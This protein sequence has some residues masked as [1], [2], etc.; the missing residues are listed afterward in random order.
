MAR[1]RFCLVLL[2]M[3]LTLSAHLPARGDGNHDA[4]ARERFREAWQAAATGQRE[5]F[6][7][8]GPD[9]RDYVLYPYWRY[10]DLRHRRATVPPEEMA[11]FLDAH[12][13]WAF[14]PGLRTAWLRSLGKA[15]R[16]PDLLRHGAGSR[17]TEVRCYHA[18]ARLAAADT[19]GL[20]Q[21]AL[22]LWTVGRSQPEA[23]DPLFAWLIE[24]GAVT[25][26]VAWERIRLAMEGGNPRL[27][28]YLG[29][30]L[31]GPDRSWLE[32]W[33]QLDRDRYRRLDRA[34]A[35]PD[36]PV[37]RR[38]AASSLRRLAKLDAPRAMS[39]YGPLSRHFD[40]DD[41][42]A[43]DLAR[44]VGL[45]AAVGLEDGAIDFIRAVPPTARDDQLH[46]WWARA[47]LAAGD[48]GQV[49]LAIE[50]LRGEAADDER[51]RYW[52]A[53]ALF[54]EGQPERAFAI[55]ESLATRT[56]YHGFLS[57]DLLRQP[58]TI[59]PK[60]PEVNDAAVEALAATPAFHRAL[61]LHRAGL[62]NWAAAEW[63]RAARALP[64]DQLK[65]AAGLA[66]REGWYDR[67][68][69]ALGDSGELHYYDWRFP[70]LYTDSV[71]ASAGNHGL[72]PAWVYGIMRSESAM[73]EH[74]RSSAGALGLMQVTPATAKTL[75]RRH[76]L[77][78]RASSQ[79][80]QGDVNIRFGTTY[81]RELLDEHGQNPVLVSGA[82]NAGPNAVKRWLESRPLDEAA[83][84]IE[85]LPYY[86][87]RDYI[88][89]VLT[90]STLYD[91][92]LK[93][94]VRRISSR[95]P[96]IESGTLPTDSTTEVVCRPA[97]PAVAAS[98]P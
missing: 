27:T 93:N 9:L 38:V 51:W 45:W 71:M 67:A 64:T 84:W 41:A 48:W 8:L 73:T 97:P 79:L 82:Y 86:E 94:P 96:G 24:Q 14:T 35:W 17:N 47:A 98:G 85:T 10:E 91:W 69:F 23:C 49:L 77:P 65:V 20:Q 76:G 13:G 36:E 62:D 42:T 33:Q 89:R 53:R 68:I 57:A 1:P 80:L 63:S 61:E 55:L 39:L 6:D 43:G 15:A 3:F 66:R 46:E 40:W 44:E 34:T 54:F 88:P 19:E 78:Y 58:Y 2:V 37:P 31:S 50:G 29:R 7:A 18:R 56:T 32:R 90:F 11:A 83:L 28:L 52:Q 75:S 26:E 81:L 12:E 25:P 92:R 60:A 87:T 5:R 59:C 21:E 72:D 70:V 74:A 22:A 95:M 4:E 30:F 16:W